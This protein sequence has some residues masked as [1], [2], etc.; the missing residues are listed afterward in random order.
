MFV[1]EVHNVKLKSGKGGNGCLSFRR[2]KFLPKGG[3][4]GGDGGD[5]G[6]LILIGDENT[7]DLSTYRFKPH[8][9]AENGQPGMGSQ[10]H[11]KNGQHCI[12]KVPVGTVI[13]DAN[14][15][16][17]VTEIVQHHQRVILL[18]GGKG[19]KG[20]I[21]FKSSTNRAPR[22]FTLGEPGQEGTY[23][24]ILKSI[25]D[26]GLVGY[27]N[28][29]KSTL[30]SL[31]TRATPKI[32]NYPFTTLHVN[33]GIM[34][35]EGRNMIIADIPG[36]IEGAHDN[37]GLGIRFLKH[38]ERC[39]ALLF[40][41][42][43]SGSDH[44]APWDDYFN[45]L[46]ELEHYDKNLLQKQ[47]MIVANK[48]EDPASLENIKIFKKKVNAPVLEISCKTQK[49][50]DELKNHLLPFAPIPHTEPE[51]LSEAAEDTTSSL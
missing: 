24:F 19:G 33:V 14:T 13:L 41:I 8:A 11:G 22:Q 27:P 23:D 38:I 29:G 49:G 4:N 26:I 15:K 47:R 37:R 31:L 44:R 39:K 25:A 48:M 21:N 17:I 35:H 6:H 1:D 10:K 36:L 40:L 7:S 50:I 3:P 16:H 51:D 20:N 18:K 34:N 28:A 45:L 5:G 30:T 43:M 12:L 2:E 9:K 42:D 32:A 46:K